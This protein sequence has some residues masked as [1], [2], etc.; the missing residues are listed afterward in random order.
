MMPLVVALNMGL[1]A[2]E[3]LENGKYPVYDIGEPMGIFS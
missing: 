1:I 3:E 2:M